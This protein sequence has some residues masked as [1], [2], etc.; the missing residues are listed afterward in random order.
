LST[1]EGGN[2]QG[3]DNRADAGALLGGVDV[4][5]GL[6]TILCFNS[7]KDFHAGIE[8]SAPIT[9]DGCAVGFIER[10][11]KEYVQ[12]RVLRLERCQC[13]GDGA[14]YIETFKG[15]GPCE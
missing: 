14:A 5:N 1:E 6:E 12:L 15:T 13:I 10:A 3:I 7:L 11:L 8:P 2:L 4:S 9:S